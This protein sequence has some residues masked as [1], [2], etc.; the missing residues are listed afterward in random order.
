M[1]ALI[2]AG[3][4]HGKFGGASAATRFVSTSRTR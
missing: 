3:F 2:A 4:D 1:M